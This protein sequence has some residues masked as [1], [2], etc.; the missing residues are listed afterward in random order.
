MQ[1]ILLASTSESE[2]WLSRPVVEH[3]S[4]GS[5]CR[6]RI[7]FC[8]AKVWL[9]RSRRSGISAQEG[10]RRGN[11]LAPAMRRVADIGGVI[12]R[13]EESLPRTPVPAVPLPWAQERLCPRINAYVTAD[14]VL[15]RS[16]QRSLIPHDHVVQALASDRAHQPLHKGILPGGSRRSKHFLHSHS[17]GHG[18]E[19]CSVDGISIA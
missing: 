18:D 1:F 14:S 17:S 3:P 11:R 5:S 9:R 6:E 8:L 12:P 15:Q 7:R 19:V 4:A 13:P 16:T 10:N 2:D